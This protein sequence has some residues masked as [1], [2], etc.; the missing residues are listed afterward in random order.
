VEP[1]TG[2]DDLAF[3][4]DLVGDARIV[5]LGE[6]NHGTHE[7]FQLKHR[8]VEYLVEEMGFDLL[9]VEANWPEANFVNDYVRSCESDARSLL[10]GLRYWTWNSQEILDLL[11]WMCAHNQTAGVEPVSFAGF[12]M[13]S[14]DTAMDSVIA[15]FEQVEPEYVREAQIGYSCLRLSRLQDYAERPQARREGCRERIQTVHDHLVAGQASYEERSSPQM[16]A[17]VEHSSSIV[18]QAEDCLADFDACERDRYM[19]DNVMWLLQQ[20]GPETK[21]ILWAH[22]DHVADRLTSAGR[23][24]G[25]Y[26][27][28]VYGQE[29]LIVGLASGD[30][31]SFNAISY[32]FGRLGG[33]DM[34][35]VPEAPR[36]SYETYLARAELERMVLDLRDVPAEPGAEWLIEP[37]GLRAIGAV[38]DPALP[39]EEYFPQVEITAEF[40]LIVYIEQTT[41]SLLLSLAML[42]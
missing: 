28:D 35:M 12:D 9:A 17:Q 29:L 40:D 1:E 14:A 30:E 22:N 23:S 4:E 21:V 26:L 8:L 36:G 10:V 5:A 38:Y 6:S 15:Y 37:R 16:F 25:S 7:F 11:Q 20:A 13:Q 42:P 24:M 33:V 31:G 32:E 34:H 2:F 27:R 41:P 39:D 18:L 19:A 3:L